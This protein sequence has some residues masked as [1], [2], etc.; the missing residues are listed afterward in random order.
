M[1][2]RKI[3]LNNRAIYMNESTPWPKWAAAQLHRWRIDCLY[4]SFAGFL[5]CDLLSHV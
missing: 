1:A 5:S 3:H 4:E 2:L